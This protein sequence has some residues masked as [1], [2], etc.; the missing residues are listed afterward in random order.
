MSQACIAGVRL[1]QYRNKSGSR[2]SAYETALRLA[3]IARDTKATFIV[4]D[5]ADIALAVDADGVHLGQDDLPFDLARKLLGPSKLIGI[6]THSVRQAQEAEL[7]GADYVGFGPI[8]PTTTKDAGVIQGISG[9]ANIRKSVKIPIIAIGGIKQESVADVIRGG[10]D[11][12]AIIG[13]ILTAEHLS[14][15]AAAVLKIIND[16][17]RKGGT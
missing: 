9:L 15:A 11:C 8:F 6:S 3:K 16:I 2:K 5:Y 10:A 13:A 17:S 14:D 12:V 4:N 7:Q 1:F